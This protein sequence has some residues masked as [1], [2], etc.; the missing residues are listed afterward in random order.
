[1]DPQKAY[2]NLVDWSISISTIQSISELLEWDQRCFMPP[3][4][5]KHRAEQLAFLARIKHEK[6]TDPRAEEWLNEAS[7]GFKDPSSVEL[8]NIRIWKRWHNRAIKIPKRLM[9]EIA[10]TTAE[11]ET[12]WEKAKKEN[13]WEIFKPYLAKIFELKKE[14]A[15]VVGWQEEPYDAL[16][17]VF[18]PEFTAKDFDFLVKGIINPLKELLDKILGSQPVDDSFLYRHFPIPLQEKFCLKVAKKLGYDLEGGRIDT[19]LHPFTVSL[20]P[21]DVRI[22]T[23]YNEKNFPEA[24]FSTIHEIGHALYDQGLDPDHWGTPVGMSVSLG[25]HESQSRFWE[26]IIAKSHSFW[27]FW[28][29]SLV[30]T[31]PVLIDISHDRFWKGINKVSPSLIRIKADEL[32]YCFHIILRYELERE[33]LKGNIEISDLPYAWKEKMKDYLG[34]E[35]KTFSDGLLQDVHWS[36]GLIGYFPTY[37]LGNIYSAQIKAKMEEEIGELDEIVSRGNFGIILYWLREKIHLNGSR[38]LPKELMVK[39]TGSSPSEKYFLEYLNEKFSTIY[40]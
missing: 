11:A 7:E 38:F 34:C 33:L 23:K 31:F 28:Y 9:E 27:K 39:I 2:K 29:S 1:M 8:A 40:N 21:N 12:I 36:A 22:T 24:F 13:D 16:F 19:S 17:D 10:K 32:T 6:L 37:L 4:A 15:D 35:P 5:Y 25:I 3:K 20:C 14:E 30:Q 26:N 18:E